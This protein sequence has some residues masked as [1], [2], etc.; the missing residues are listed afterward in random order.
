[1]SLH[2]Y[3][4]KRVHSLLILIL[5]LLFTIFNGSTNSET[6]GIEVVQQDI[7]PSQS[8]LDKRT[9][10][11]S[12]EDLFL[13]EE[14]QKGCFNYFWNEVGASA[15]LALDSTV[16][17]ICSIASVGFQ[18]S[19]LPIGVEHGWVTR[20][21]AEE[22]AVTV[23]KSLLR[24]DNNKKEGIYFHFL[25]STTGGR[26]D[27]SN[28]KRHY[29]LMASTIDHS[30]FQSGVMTASSYFGG[31]VKLLAD[32]IIAEANWAHYRVAPNNY[33]SMGWNAN[34]N[35]KR[36]KPNELWPWYW[37]T[38]SDEE[39]LIYFL[40]VGA[41]LDKYAIPPSDYYRLRRPIEQYEDEKPFVVAPN[42]GLFMYF[43]SHCWIDYGAFKADN[44]QSL[45]VE[46]PSVDWFENTRRAAVT[47]RRRCIESAKQYPTLG[48]NRWGLSPCRAESGYCVQLIQPNLANRDSWCRGVVPPYGAA[49][50]LPML[51]KESM[52]ALRE[53]RSLKS[54]DGKELIWRDPSGGGYGFVDAFKLDPP[55]PIE[56]YIGIDQGPMLLA[57]ENARTGLIWK[58]FMQHEVAQNAA[59]RL[60]FEARASL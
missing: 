40:A 60:N 26:P 38:A 13:L 14:I 55:T 58:L 27:S 29:E 39:R 34:P 46:G 59:R 10:K 35:D 17:D 33:L 45:G 30:L 53:Y 22:R 31:E 50:V 9:H 6:I 48:E 15:C 52:A 54:K 5:L 3:A 4:D 37:E 16:G 21:L 42:G 57:I 20:K 51:P 36:Q 7:V 43:F 23:L 28:G 1:M 11:F 32:Q 18:L 19:S 24:H 56:A 41:P 12:Q 47:H 2:L 25:E 49:G 8:V 44:P